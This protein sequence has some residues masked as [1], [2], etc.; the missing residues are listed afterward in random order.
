[1]G[2]YKKPKSVEEVQHTVPTPIPEATL[3][4]MATVKAEQEGQIMPASNQPQ[5]KLCQ[6]IVR[7]TMRH[8]NNFPLW[9][10]PC[11]DG[12]LG[13]ITQSMIGRF[14]SCRERFRLKYILGLEPFP[15]WS[16]RLGYGTMWH[17]CEEAHAKC[18]G[19]HTWDKTFAPL[20]DH[21]EQLTNMFPMQR[22]ELYKWYMV[23]RTQF[24]EYLKYWAD[25]SDVRNRHP[26]MQEQVFDIPYRLISGRIVRL[27]GK[28]DSVD[29]IPAHTDSEGRNWPDGIWLQEN[30]TKGDINRV[31][32]ERQ[33]KFDLQSMLYLIALE[34]VRGMGGELGLPST[35]GEPILGV[36]YNVVRRPLGSGKGNI[37]PHKAK[38]LKNKVVPAE[39]PDEFFER[40][41][42]DYFETEPDYWF[43][44]VRA[45]V[46]SDDIGV[47]QETCLDPILEN[48][49]WWYESVT[50]K[51]C[52]RWEFHP[53]NFNYRTPFGVY[54]AMTE[55]GATEYDSYLETGSEVG[56]RRTEELFTE[57]K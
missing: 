7:A 53:S 9:Q 18:E 57:L 4:Y 8:D 34:E 42:R 26:L 14:L 20:Q 5:S 39:T 35:N 21:F 37:S 15:K 41:R 33:L 47:F 29:F 43:F 50:K 36:R 30:K 49:C 10:G 3:A 51:L 55:A 11:A 54:N 40:L 56:L 16:H 31:Q 32:V 38:Y 25:H 27:R 44:R 2:S 6:N 19:P 17:I 12:P 28:F 45:E 46:T 48:I 23:C 24:P 22:E 1:M 52:T 13:G